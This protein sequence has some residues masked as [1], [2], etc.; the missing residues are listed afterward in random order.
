VTVN[1]VPNTVRKYEVALVVDVERVGEEIISLP[2]TAKSLVPE[3]TSA[4]PV[5]NYGRCFLR[6]P[7][8]QQISL[9]ND[10]DLA[11]KYEIVRQ[12]EDHAETLPISY[13]SPKPK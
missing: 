13:G 6:Y 5:L 12:N 1:L 8:E 2:I 10:T 9:H 3:I 11:A 7:Y 4:M